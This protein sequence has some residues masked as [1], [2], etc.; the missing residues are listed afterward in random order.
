MNTRSVCVI[1]GCGFIGRHV[2]HLLSQRS[3]NVMVPTR[4]R[5]RGRELFLLPTV[6]V[7]EADIFDPRQ[8]ARAVDGQDAVI[9]LVG[10]LREA[11][12]GDFHRVHE[13]LPRRLVEACRT[14]K[15]PRLIHVSALGAAH[16]G[17]SHYLRS[18]AAGEAQIR[19]ALAAG[20]ATTI[21]RPSVVFGADDRFLNPLARLLRYTPLMLLP[22]A[23]ARVQPVFVEDL[24]RVCVGILDRADT[25]E[26]SLSVCGPHVYRLIDLVRWLARVLE[27]QRSVVPLNSSISMLFATL[28]EWL[29]GAPLSRDMVRSS[30]LDSV[31]STAFPE[32]AGAPTPLEAVA[33]TW[34]SGKDTRDTYYRYR[35]HN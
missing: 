7:V 21:V 22:C 12:R 30:R 5:E 13:D 10:I 16:D 26:Q 17:P 19:L 31:C 8:L 25:F 33:P 29:P 35:S 24:A 27:L 3:I 18:K 2:V 14:L 28:T 32:F 9:N 6:E 11:H 23:H 34:L 15:V 20:I 1:G 4:R